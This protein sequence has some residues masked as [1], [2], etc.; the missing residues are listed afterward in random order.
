VK[1]DQVAVQLYTLRKTCTTASEYGATLKRVREI[2]YKFIEISGVGAIS[3][4]ELRSIADNEGLTI[5]GTHEP[6]LTILNEPEKV[7]EK[8]QILGCKYTAYPHPAG[9]DL[10]D[11]AQ[12]E[13]LIAALDKAGAVLTQA[14]L[15]LCYHNHANEFAHYKGRPVL[16]A[17]YAGTRPEH[18][19]AEIDTYWV[20]AGGANPTEWCAKLSGRL[21]VL[22]LKDY[23]VDE[24]GTPLFAEIGYGNLDFK[25][26]I[27]AAETSGCQYFV[28]EQDTC[29]ADP[30]VSIQ[31]S[32]QY[33]QENLLS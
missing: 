6:A 27:A 13:R 32:L 4:E 5:C 29:P 11:P 21:P 33:I 3:P 12:V 22:H 18:L 17:I 19:Q 7:V 25:A 15:V 2:G 20:Q 16:E 23:A 26:I 1:L 14:G 8:L 10:R 9:V 24:Y 30:F 31:K 28:V